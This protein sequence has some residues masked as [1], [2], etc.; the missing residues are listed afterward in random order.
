MVSKKK[1]KVG[2]LIAALLSLSAS[3]PLKKKIGSE[4]F[5]YFIEA[6][7]EGKHCCAMMLSNGG[8]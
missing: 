4:G 3:W 2:E 7:N 1:K 5:K 8:Y 6:G